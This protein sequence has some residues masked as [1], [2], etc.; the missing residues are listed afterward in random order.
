MSGPSPEVADQV[1][2]RMHPSKLSVVLAVVRRLVP[3][4]VEATLIPTVLFYVFLTV[5]DLRWAL[6][7]ALGWTYCAVG[8]R[9]LPGEDGGPR[10]HAHHRRWGGP[11]VA[12]ALGGQPVDDGGAGQRAAVAAEGFVALLVGGDEE[13]LAPHQELRLSGAATRQAQPPV[14]AAGPS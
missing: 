9:V 14:L 13:D 10:R 11:L 1:A 3:Y 8:R 4:L 2:W 6:V 12:D 7:A 5:L